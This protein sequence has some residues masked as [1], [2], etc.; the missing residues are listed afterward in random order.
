MKRTGPL[1]DPEVFRM[2]EFTLTD[3]QN[4]GHLKMRVGDTIVL[5]LSETSAA[6]YR[7]VVTGLDQTLIA[8]MSQRYQTTGAN[9]GGAGT[10][11]WTLT[12]KQTGTTQLELRKSRPWEKDNSAS[13]RFSVGVDI[14]E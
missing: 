6:G 9:V 5:H 13:E 11:V 7:W 14:T 12:A 4:G 2:A 3:A 1:F 8:L 10:G